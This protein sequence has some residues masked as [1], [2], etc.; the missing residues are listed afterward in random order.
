MSPDH[1]TQTALTSEKSRLRIGG[2]SPHRPGKL[3]DAAGSSGFGKYS[4][5][6]YHGGPV[7]N[8]PQVH[9]LFVGNWNSPP[10]QNRATRLI[11]FVSDL[12]SSRYMNILSQYG[13]G[14]TGTV[15]GTTIVPTADN[16][17]SAADIHNLIQSAINNNQIPEPVDQATCALLY[18]DDATAVNDTTSGAVLCEATSDN[19]FGYHDHFVTT[20]G[21][22]YPFAIVPGLTDTCLKNSCPSDLKCTLHLSATQEQRQTQVTSHEL[23]EMF[24]N[25]QVG[26]NE[27]WSRPSTGPND[28]HENG[29]ICNGES[30]TITVGS[31]TW[32]I[33]MMYSKYDDMFSNGA[34]TCITDSDSLPSLLPTG[35]RR[36]FGR[37]LV[38]NTKS[39]YAITTDGRLAQVYDAANGWNL[40]FPAEAAGQAALRFAGSPAVF[41]RDLV[42]NTKSIYAITTDGRLAQV[43][44]AA[45]G[46]NLDFPAEAAGQA[47]LRFA[48]SPAVFGRDLVHNT[49]SIYAITTDGRLAQVYDAANGW[50]LDFPAEAANPAVLR[51][52]GSPAVFGRDLVHNTKSIYAITTDGRLAQVYDAANGWNLD[53][54]A[55]AANPAVLRFAGSPAVFGRDL[56]HNTKSIYAITTDGRLAQ[57][58]DAANGWNLDFPAEAAN[59]AVLR[60]AGS[61]AV[62]GRDL[63]H[64]TKSI[65]AI[66]TDGRLAQVYDAANGWNLDFPAEAANP[67]VLRFAGS[68]AVFGRDLVH[69]TKSI[70][71]ITTDG[72]LAQV[73]DAANGWNLDFPAEA[74]NPAVLRFEGSV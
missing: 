30:A 32:T 11:Q 55:E 46:W 17:L 31:N 63:V 67:A 74:A 19:A 41:G 42:H 8:S 18:L 43:Y 14:T 56:V 61:P 3:S 7:I 10:N 27:A 15:A 38:H 72:R 66:T 12:L 35:A 23:S 33:Q 2:V 6:I 16:N 20:A 21:N 68:P 54:P 69:N 44:D 24:S 62:F 36:V 40:D 53:F 47:A 5:F 51:F 45:N 13:C 50:N 71:A 73:Y 39:I 28:P 34:T 57:V 70:Y 60:F 4:D 59:P 64:N 25:P 65:Y 37:D 1:S 49:K 26:S 48:G 52:A 22:S 58:Y 9:I 29:D